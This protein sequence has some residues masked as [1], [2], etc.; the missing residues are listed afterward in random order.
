M[1]S[2]VLEIW[3][4]PSFILCCCFLASWSKV[5]KRSQSRESRKEEDASSCEEPEE[6]EVSW[7]E[8]AVDSSAEEKEDSDSFEEK[9][10]SSFEEIEEDSFCE[11]KKEEEMPCWGLQERSYSVSDSH[12]MF[13]LFIFSPF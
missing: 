9:E 11:E 3:I 5:K 8:T 12:K 4:S 2:P 7:L 6:I 1:S 10:D 13:F